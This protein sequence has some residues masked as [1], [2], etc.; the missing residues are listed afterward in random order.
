MPFF[1]AF[2]RRLNFDYLEKYC[3]IE[4]KGGTLGNVPKVTPF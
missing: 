4:P 2:V 3:E 1:R